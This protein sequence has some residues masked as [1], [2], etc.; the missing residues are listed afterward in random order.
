MGSGGAIIG[1]G[2]AI[3]GSGGIGSG[4]D[5]TSGGS[6]G[7]DGLGGDG[8]GG[9]DGL[10]GDDG[11]G[12]EDGA[13]GSGGSSGGSGGTGGSD[14]TGG[15]GGGCAEDPFPTL[16]V[17]ARDDDNPWGVNDFDD[18]LFDDGCGTV[19]VE[20]TWPHEAG[21]ADADPSE[22]NQEQVHFTASTPYT[23]DL[24]GKQINLTVTLLDDGRG[25]NAT[26]GGYNVYFGAQDSDFSE[27]ASAWQ[28]GELY[29]A[30]ST[31]TISYVIPDAGG[32]WDPADVIRLIVRVES[33]YWSG[34]T[35]DY[36]TSV[37]ELSELT[38]TDVIP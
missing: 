29:G 13:G 19:E 33:K 30:G 8:S 14:G 4:G 15:T 11:S 9:D 3:I 34:P 25:P 36:D 5:L 18:V 20:A 35:F 24:T 32:G 6:G 10:G 31:V 26:N 1:S 22:A 12:G 16:E 28:D 38:V 21:Y 7:D 17:D 23:D 37:L 27:K 2:G